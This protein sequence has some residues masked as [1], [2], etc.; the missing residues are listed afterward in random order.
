MPAQSRRKGKKNHAHTRCNG[1]QRGCI[2]SKPRHSALALRQTGAHSLHTER[3]AQGKTCWNG[4]GVGN[5][6][7]CRLFRRHPSNEASRWIARGEAATWTPPLDC[8]RGSESQGHVAA[9]RRS[10]ATRTKKGSARCHREYAVRQDPLQ[11]IPTDSTQQQQ[12]PRCGLLRLRV[13]LPRPIRPSRISPTERCDLSARDCGT[14]VIRML[15]RTHSK[16]ASAALIMQKGPARATCS[17]RLS[18]RHAVLRMRGSVGQEDCISCAVPVA[19]VSRAQS[20]C[21]DMLCRQSTYQLPQH[22]G[23]LI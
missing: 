22:S 8:W 21:S 16:P 18:P 10:E 17:A 13:Q 19:T 7:G 3:H 6:S 14:S 4:P 23:R 1:F 5:V 15:H 9:L 2:S 12:Q 11:E 20:S